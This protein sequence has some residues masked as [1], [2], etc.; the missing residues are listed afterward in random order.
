M[1]LLPERLEILF[2]DDAV[3]AAVKP[4]GMH[5]FPSSRGE[6]QSAWVLLKEMRPGL[7]KVGDPAAPAFVHRLDRGTSGI[8]LAAKTNRAYRRL[9]EAFEKGEVGKEYLALVEG[10][11]SDLVEVDLPI[12]TRYRRSAKVQVQLPG[13]NLRGVRPARTS[14]EP[15]AGSDDLTLCRVQIQTGVR[16]QIRAHL[17]YL[18]HPVA[19]DLDYGA[20][21]R[22]SNLEDRFFLHAWQACLSHPQTGSALAICCPLPP[23]L[24][25]ILNNLGIQ[26]PRE[27]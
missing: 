26:P 19:G 20:S 7:D 21:R 25:Q 5:V 18:G 12:G 15:L 14:A 2:E 23:D 22:V 24:V 11:L 27:P 16:H 1:P 4:A 8:L 13:R 9:R 17:S 6:P 3:L 10:V